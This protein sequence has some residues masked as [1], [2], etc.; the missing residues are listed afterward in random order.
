[1]YAYVQITRTHLQHFSDFFAQKVWIFF[2]IITNT[3]MATCWELFHVNGSFLMLSTFSFFNPFLW[4][5]ENKKKCRRSSKKWLNFSRRQKKSYL[6]ISFIYSAV[7]CK[8]L[9]FLIFMPFH[10]LLF[11]FRQMLNIIFGFQASHSLIGVGMEVIS[12]KL[13]ISVAYAYVRMMSHSTVLLADGC[14]T[15]M[16]DKLCLLLSHLCPLP[17]FVSKK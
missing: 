17:F 9:T 5:H 11:P 7:C 2:I 15:Y 4:L 10:S 3:H 1:M 8:K 12:L 14:V 13:F 6:L 16:Q